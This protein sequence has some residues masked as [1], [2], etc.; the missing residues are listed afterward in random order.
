MLFLFA[1][2]LMGVYTNLAIAQSGFWAT[3]LWS[4]V[5]AQVLFLL[6]VPLFWRDLIKTKIKKYSGLLIMS[7][8]SA[9]GTLAAN[10]AYAVNVGISSTIMALPFSMIFT[11]I[12]S[13][14]NPNILEHHTAKIYLLRIVAAV[15]MLF[16][17]LQLSK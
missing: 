12:I 4:M 1:L 2:A 6:T 16:A 8:A 13:T 10:Q 15:I 7:V 3:T 14:I 11:I 9:G 5:L 17:A